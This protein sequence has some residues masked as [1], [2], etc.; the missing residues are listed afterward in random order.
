MIAFNYVED[1][2]EY[3]A[4]YRTITGQLTNSWFSAMYVPVISLA[5]YDVKIIDS[6]AT[7]TIQGT[8]LTDRQAELAVKIIHNYQRQLS[9]QGVA[10]NFGDEPIYRMKLRIIDRSCRAWYDKKVYLQFLFN[11]DIID[12]IKRD[13]RS[14]QG[15]VEFDRNKKIW[16]F[17]PTEYNI[18]LAY[19]LADQHQFTIDSSLQELMEQILEV[20]KTPYKIELNKSDNELVITNAPQPLI[21]YINQYC[22]GFSPSNL[23][24]LIDNT[25][26]LGYQVSEEL[27]QQA[28]EQ[29]DPVVLQLMQNTDS[30]LAVPTATTSDSIAKIFSKLVEYAELCNRWPIFVHEPLPQEVNYNLKELIKQHA[31]PEQ[32][33]ITDRIRQL[34][35]VDTNKKFVYISK[36]ISITEDLHVPLLIS[37]IG[38]YFGGQKQLLLQQAEKVVYFT[39]DVYNKLD[40]SAA[41]VVVNL[42]N[43]I[44][45]PKLD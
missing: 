11:T 5:R 31:R 37:T 44:Q 10:V 25:G 15:S 29:F 36:K 35:K 8:A 2:I 3:I 34:K 42:E 9:T 28:Q 32:I 14:A 18:N 17:A 7:Q 40:R 24:A 23:P 20:E 19:Q 13:R 43:L 41:E 38:M 1:Y 21:D 30:R 6:L 33:L 22:G 45:C 27:Q 26:V 39:A 4:G 16:V 12:H